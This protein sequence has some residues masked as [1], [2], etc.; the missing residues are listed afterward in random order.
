MSN[1]DCI[2]FWESCSAECGNG[3]QKFT[4]ITDQKGT[5]KKCIAPDGYTMPCKKKECP[6]NCVGKWSPCD[7]ECGPGIKKFEERTPSQYGG[8][9]CEK[10]YGDLTDKPCKDKECPINC[11]GEWSPC[12]KECG[13]GVQKFRQ[14]TPSQYG[15]DTCEKIYGDLTDK[16]CKDKECPINCV[17]EWSPCDKECG[18]GV[19]KF[20][21]I[22]PSQYGGDTCEKIYGDLTD[23]PCNNGACAKCMEPCRLGFKQNQNGQSCIANCPPNYLESGDYC[24]VINPTIYKGCCYSIFNKT[25][26]GSKCP[27][28]YENYND[29]SCKLITD[30]YK[31]ETYTPITFVSNRRTC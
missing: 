11:V 6:I 26:D 22:T 24:T 21:Q 2:G 17:G 23:K 1:V 8:D 13:P 28:G 25:C 14:I 12:D 16:P 3:T 9:T 15:G 18:P 10:I 29:C 5:G 27:S 30:K 19:Q 31:R 4:I 7:K 20:R